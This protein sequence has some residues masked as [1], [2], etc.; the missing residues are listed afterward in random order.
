MRRLWEAIK[1][2]PPYQG[3]ILSGR[4]DGVAYLLGW[5]ATFAHLSLWVIVLAFGLDQPWP[6]ISTAASIAA[7]LLLLAIVLV[8]HRRMGNRSKLTRAVVWQWWLG[9]WDSVGRLVWLPVRLPEAA[10]AAAGVTPS[11]GEKPLKG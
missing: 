4:F 9:P 7:T 11:F 10:R 3:A 6:I 1:F 5:T 8:I 2:P